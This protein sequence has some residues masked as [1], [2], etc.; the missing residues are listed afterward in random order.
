MAVFAYLRVSSERQAESGAGL[1]AQRDAIQKC[2]GT[3]G[4][5]IAA[6]FEDQA[7]SRSEPID[8]RAGLSALLAIAREGDLIL[9]QKWDR[10]GTLLEVSLLLK[11]LGKQ[12]VTIQVVDGSASETAEGELLR[13]LLLSISQFELRQI[14]N[15]TKAA[16]RAKREKGEAYCRRKYGFRAIEGRFV[17]DAEEQAILK[18]IAETVARGVSLNAVAQD[19]NH[20]GIASPNGGRWAHSTVGRIVKRFQPATS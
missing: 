18:E 11:D 19:L 10:F 7:V 1:S 9:A 8:E 16:L 20:R 6:F 17:A 4:L 13:N 12:G 14:R 15:R 5:T 3:Q 2:A